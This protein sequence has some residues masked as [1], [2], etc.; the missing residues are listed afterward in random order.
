MNKKK[1]SNILKKTETL[2]TEKVDYLIEMNNLHLMTLIDFV[3][4]G[5]LKTSDLYCEAIEKNLMFLSSL[6]DLQFEKSAL[7]K[8]KK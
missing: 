7:E 8:K 4:R 5:K 1:Q 3:K 6:S 2:T